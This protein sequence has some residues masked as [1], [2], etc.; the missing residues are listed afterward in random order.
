[1]QSGSASAT[2]FSPV[3]PWATCLPAPTATSDHCSCAAHLTPP[4]ASHPTLA[5]MYGRYLCP[6]NG[7]PACPCACARLFP[8]QPLFA[9]RGPCLPPAV[10]LRH[11]CFCSG[12]PPPASL[13][14]GGPPPPQL[15][16]PPLQCGGPPPRS[17]GG[18]PPSWS[19]GP[20]PP[21]RR[22]AE[23][24]S[25]ESG[26]IASTV[27]SLSRAPIF[28]PDDAR[29]LRCQLCRHR[30]RSPDPLATEVDA[31]GGTCRPWRTH[32]KVKIDGQWFRVPTG[33]NC[34]PCFNVF[35]ALGPLLYFFLVAFLI[36]L[37]L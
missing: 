21:H 22:M 37:L 29:E 13:Q 15:P 14:R 20:P 10:S 31:A 24:D 33:R 9:L 18:P 17:S 4:R 2:T 34:L 27:G 25:D 8:S 7:V 1:M 23:N 36:F 5:P 28:I 30:Q 35:C 19:G 32:K 3:M 6:N 12:G 16:V 11:L 26:G